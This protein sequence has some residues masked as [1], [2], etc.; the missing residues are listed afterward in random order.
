MGAALRK[1]GV[2]LAGRSRWDCFPRVFLC[3]AVGVALSA[4]AL[5]RVVE[6]NERVQRIV[7]GAG[8]YAGVRQKI[9]PKRIVF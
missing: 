7:A 6:V 3:I 1:S 9:R 5:K 8:V 4:H 2:S